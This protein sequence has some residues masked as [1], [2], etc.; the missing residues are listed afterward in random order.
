MKEV[1]GKAR[2]GVARMEGTTAKER[3][4]LA[5]KAAAARWGNDIK[6]VAH[7]DDDHPLRI[8]EIEIPC[9]VLDDETRVLSQRGVVVG[10]LGIQYGGGS[11]RDGADRL[12][13]FLQGKILSPFVSNELLALVQNPIK[14]R[15]P[16][17]LAHGYPATILADICDVVL[18][19]RS[20]GKLQAQQMHI[21]ERCEILVRGFARVGIIAL[22]DEATGFQYARTRNS[23]A[24]ILEAFVTKELQPWVKTFP[25][26]F[27]AQLFRLRG[28]KYDSDSVKRPQ[29][30]GT[31]TNDIVWKRIAPGV[32]TELK[33][34]IPKDASGRRKA[35][36]AQ[37]LT[38][39]IG[40][41]KLREHLGA[42][43]AYMTVSPDYPTFI[44]TLDAHRPRFHD[45]LELPFEYKPDED[46]G[47]GL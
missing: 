37:A 40:Y 25:D 43:V 3:R 33:R 16:G 27:Y 29:Y 31:L 46:D 41:P 9:Y 5:T 39:N 7:G 35:T 13:S 12:T 38:R 4:A 28:L 17:G 36:L 8:G 2:G 32:L 23:L 14:F 22:V 18:N 10:G 20:A 21:A 19:A 1:S 11:V 6:S 42:T 30:F 15:S 34:V 24:R 26:E 44:K 47:K 45:Q